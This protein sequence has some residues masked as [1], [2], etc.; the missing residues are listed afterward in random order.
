MNVSFPVAT[1][2]LFS[3]WLTLLMNHPK[4][5]QFAQ[6]EMPDPC[7]WTRVVRSMSERRP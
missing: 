3:H 2:R 6:R 5:S 1:K 4:I 7:N